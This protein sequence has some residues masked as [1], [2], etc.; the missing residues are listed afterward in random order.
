MTSGCN[1]LLP[2]LTI[3]KGLRGSVSVP[4]NFKT[5]Q[6]KLLNC[7]VICNHHFSASM[8]SDASASGCKSELRIRS[9]LQ[10]FMAILKAF[11][12]H[13][14][15]ESLDKML[16]S[17]FVQIQTKSLKLNFFASLPL[18]FIWTSFVK[19]FRKRL[20]IKLSQFYDFFYCKY[21][22]YMQKELFFIK[23][24]IPENHVLLLL[25]NSVTAEWFLSP[26]L[27]FCNKS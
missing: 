4:C 22:S 1:H 6:P 27:Y 7:Y 11:L 16:N 18:K 3:G 2:K 23:K 19:H 10:A 25:N 17:A 24:K 5:N 20:C 12:K 9:W 15:V 21:E 8:F 14:D 26:I 13:F